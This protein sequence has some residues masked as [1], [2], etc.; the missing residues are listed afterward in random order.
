MPRL[1]LCETDHASVTGNT[2]CALCAPS[3]GEILRENAKM[4]SSVVATKLSIRSRNLGSA[5]NKA[6]G[7]TTQ[8]HNAY[9]R[10][11][12]RNNLGRHI[13]EQRATVRRSPSPFVLIATGRNVGDGLVELGEDNN[14]GH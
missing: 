10:I 9:E 7:E 8:L 5:E 14:K 11:I 13:S 6:R 3:D 2:L 4:T 12:T 1:A